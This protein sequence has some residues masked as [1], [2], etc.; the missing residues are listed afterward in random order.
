MTTNLNAERRASHALERLGTFEPRC[1][2]CGEVHP[3]CLEKHHI[4]GRAADATTTIL[5]RNC[6]RKVS[7]PQKDHPKPIAKPPAFEECVGLFLLGLADLFEMLIGKMREFG[8]ALMLTVKDRA[9]T[10]GGAS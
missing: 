6:H 4:A 1:T 10:T 2:C 9:A 8:Q 5:C 3:H 7:D